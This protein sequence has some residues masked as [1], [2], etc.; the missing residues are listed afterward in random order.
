MLMN[1]VKRGLLHPS[2]SLFWVISEE[3]VYTVFLTVYEGSRN[4][5]SFS[6]QLPCGERARRGGGGWRGGGWSDSVLEL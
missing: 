3:Y 2:L 6:S 5:E 4:V 1:T